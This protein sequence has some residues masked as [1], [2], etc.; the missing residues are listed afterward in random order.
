MTTSSRFLWPCQSWKQATQCAGMSTGVPAGRR[1][2]D[3]WSHVKVPTWHQKLFSTDGFVGVNKLEV[4]HDYR[5]GQHVKSPR[6]ALSS[7]N[8]TFPLKLGL[9]SILNQ[10]EATTP[11]VCKQYLM[12]SDLLINL[13]LSRP[14]L[15]WHRVS[16]ISARDTMGPFG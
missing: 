5:S 9:G 4:P 15:L 13:A 1:G 11:F 16:R 7:A 3:R 6:S 10:S 14:I 8:K 12:V 2:L